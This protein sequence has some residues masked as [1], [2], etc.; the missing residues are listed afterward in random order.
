MSLRDRPLRVMVAMGLMMHGCAPALA[1]NPH[2]VVGAPYRTG[3]V[4]HYPQENFELDA[5]GLAVVAKGESGRLT[6]DGEIFDQ[7]ALAGGHATLQLPSIARLTN[8]ENGR[9]VI[10]RINDRGTGDPRRLLEVT[11]RTALLLDMPPNGVTRIGM[12]VL[13]SESHAAADSL[14]GAPMLAMATA[15]RADIQTVELMPLPG[16]RRGGGRPMFAATEAAP[17]TATVTPPALRLPETVSQTMPRPGHL[18]VR[19]DVFDEFQYAA[20]EQ[21]K[22]ASVGAK[23]VTVAQGR[24]RRFRVDV[25]PLPDV[26]QRRCRARP[27]AGSWHTRRPYRGGLTGGSSRC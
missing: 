12:Q 19:L 13:S 27:G 20:I 2:Y 6:T 26:C 14:S 24:T 7:T 21:A 17:A 3:S 4:W 23:I 10:M 22:M 16:A 18:V 15:P 5:T 8:L 1:P 11:R 25:G 9:Q